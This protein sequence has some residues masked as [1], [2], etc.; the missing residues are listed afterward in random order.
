VAEVATLYFTDS[1]EKL[2]RLQARLAAAASPPPPW[3]EVDAAVHQFKGA[4]ASF[5]AAAVVAGCVRTREACSAGDGAAVC[6]LLAATRQ[7][8]EALRARMEAY[9]ALDAR[10]KALERGGG[11]GGV[12]TA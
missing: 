11:G 6:A 5:G 2:D 3:S 1:A 4:S 8:F 10:R 7:A 12:A 9:L